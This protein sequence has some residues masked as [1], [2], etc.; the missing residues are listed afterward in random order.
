MQESHVTFRSIKLHGAFYYP[1]VRAENVA[2]ASG[3]S[4]DL[5]CCKPL[6]NTVVQMNICI[7]N[8]LIQPFKVLNQFIFQMEFLGLRPL[9]HRTKIKAEPVIVPK[10]FLH[11]FQMLRHL[12]HHVRGHIGTH[13]NHNI[14]GFTVVFD[15]DNVVHH[16]VIASASITPDFQF[17]MG[18]FGAINGYLEKRD[19][20]F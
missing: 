5:V 15:G 10:E 18:F 19:M 2:I 16:R 11:C 8:R 12:V 17:V 6:I 4:T 13:R 1:S 3:C 14:A 9:S 7:D 20:V